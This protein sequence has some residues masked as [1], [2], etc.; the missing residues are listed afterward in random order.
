[1]TEPLLPQEISI[2]N[3]K[4]LHL[5]NGIT[6]IAAGGWHTLGLKSDGTVIACGAKDYGQCEVDDWQDIVAIAA[7][8]AFSFGIKSD[9]TVVVAGKYFNPNA[10]DA[11]EVTLD[12]DE[13]EWDE[14]DID[15]DEYFDDVP[16]YPTEEIDS[17]DFVGKTFVLTGDF[18]NCKES[19][20]EVKKLIEKRGGR[21]TGSVSGKTNFLVTWRFRR[22]W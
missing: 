4:N 6:A 18:Q 17:L 15:W 2:K 22:S 16:D 21:C 11:S 7:G 12:M 9:G 5:G 19:R 1:M 3:K 13:A 10:A 20:D 14:E 8:H